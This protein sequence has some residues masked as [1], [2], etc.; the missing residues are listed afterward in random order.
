MAIIGVKMNILPKELVDQEIKSICSRYKIGH[1]SARKHINETI[2]RHPQLIQKIQENKRGHI[3]RLKAYKRF[4]KD[5]KKTIY[6]QLRQYHQ[7]SANESTLKQQL[8][9]F[10]KKSDNSKTFDNLLIDLLA[11]HVSSKERLPYYESFYKQLFDLINTPQ[12]IV[13]IGCGMHPLSY[14]FNKNLSLDTY[15][16]IDKDSSVIDILQLFAPHILPVQLKPVCIAINDIDWANYLEQ[17]MQFDLAIMLKLIPV[18]HRQSKSSMKQL[19]HIPAKRI[20]LTG[21][22]ESMTRRENIRRKEEQILRNYIGMTDRNVIATFQ[23]D[24]EFGMLI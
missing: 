21:N 9:N 6:Y 15:L 16:A 5:V 18:L 4:I 8:A 7:D 19:F 13:D 20:F 14:P 17:G 23:V 22:M 24:N 11:S 12:S 1:E 3:T 10:N 2:Q